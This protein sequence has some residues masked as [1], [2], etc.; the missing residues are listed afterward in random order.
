VTLYRRQGDCKECRGESVKGQR[1]YDNTGREAQAKATRG[2]VL[3]AAHRVIL[4]RGYT[5]T[6][7]ALIAKDAGVSVETLYKGFGSKSELITQMLG[8]VLVGDDEPVPLAERPEARVVATQTSGAA[9]L[10][11]YAAWCRQLYDRLGTLPALLL[12][13]ARSGETDLQA[14]AT[15]VKSKRLE[16]AT[17]TAEALL[18]TGELR[19]DLDHAHVRDV[20]WT[21]NS[22]EMHQL[23]TQDRQWSPEAYQHWLARTLI[24]ALLAT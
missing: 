5:A 2:R 4:A 3:D 22:P 6:T 23:L 8:A 21:L 14:F 10:T 7:M 24:D 11:A 13:A 1:R 12:I 18:G 19:P 17:T 15:N 9:M 16:D 20:I